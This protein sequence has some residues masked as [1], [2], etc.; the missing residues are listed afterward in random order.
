MDCFSQKLKGTLITMAT[1][2]EILETLFSIFTT[3][4]LC[5]STI[6]PPTQEFRFE[7]KREKKLLAIDGVLVAVGS[8][9]SLIEGGGKRIAD[10]CSWVTHLWYNQAKAVFK[11]RDCVW[12]DEWHTQISKVLVG[13]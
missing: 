11:K 13:E 4:V 5:H 10:I 9:Q 1:A 7:K 3:C 12:R 6:S 2:R 8:L